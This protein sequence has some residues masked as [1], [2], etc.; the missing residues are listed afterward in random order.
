MRTLKISVNDMQVLQDL[1][2]NFF[3]QAA[4]GFVLGVLGRALGDRA[5]KK[6]SDDVDK[7]LPKAAGFFT[8]IMA[9]L[10]SPRGMLPSDELEYP[11]QY[12]NMVTTGQEQ[13]I[14]NLKKSLKSIGQD[15]ASAVMQRD[16]LTKIYNDCKET[17]NGKFA[18]MERTAST[19]GEEEILARKKEMHSLRTNNHDLTVK[20]AI[21]ERRLTGLE[22]RSESGKHPAVP[23]G[24]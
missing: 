2:H 10:R 9:H 16:H 20:L 21:L 14:S 11:E 7:C 12:V 15:L 22:Y 23:D 1:L 19:T 17:C 6:S 13:I 8:R 3:F 24:V 5:A 18:I 4:V